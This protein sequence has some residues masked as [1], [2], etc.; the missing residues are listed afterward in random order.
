MN[1][2]FDRLVKM[3]LLLPNWREDIRVDEA[4]QTVL[5][6]QQRKGNSKRKAPASQ[7]TEKAPA[8]LTT[9]LRP[10][11]I[12]KNIVYS[13]GHTVGNTV[14]VKRQGRPPPAPEA[15]RY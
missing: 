13:P 8:S 7:T 10:H 6:K 2:C 4:K 14:V 3:G 11:K 12:N 9:W 1:A 5:S 15:T